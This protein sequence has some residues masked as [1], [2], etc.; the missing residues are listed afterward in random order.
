[1]QEVG[2]R[3]RT[4]KNMRVHSPCQ[5]EEDKDWKE[6]VPDLWMPWV[7]YRGLAAQEEEEAGFIVVIV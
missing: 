6:R 7:L 3:N 2:Q 5:S 4:S 1:M